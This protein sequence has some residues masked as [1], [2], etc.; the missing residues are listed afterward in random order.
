MPSYLL[1]N[2]KSI[3]PNPQ[4]KQGIDD[5]DRSLVTIFLQSHPTPLDLITKA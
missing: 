1:K 2:P 3:T 4:K 5:N